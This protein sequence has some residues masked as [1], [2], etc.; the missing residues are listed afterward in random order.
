VENIKPI[1]DLL[2]T[3]GF[4][5]SKTAWMK[6]CVGRSKNF[7]RSQTM[8]E[9]EYA[10]YVHSLKKRDSRSVST[11][12]RWNRV[13]GINFG[14]PGKIQGTF[15]GIPEDSLQPCRKQGQPL[16]GSGTVQHA[17]IP[18]CLQIDPF[19]ESTLLS[20]Q[21]P[22]SDFFWGDACRNHIKY[23]RNFCYDEVNVL[24]INPSMPLP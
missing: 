24:K 7:Y 19:F 4:R 2:E 6:K 10:E 8:E 11:A 16:L 18:S 15:R 1:Y 12:P 22:E 14:C 23:M 3:L 5:T 9:P 21:D 17:G 20:G 13:L